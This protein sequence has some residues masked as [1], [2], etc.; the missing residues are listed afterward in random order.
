MKQLYLDR[1]LVSAIIYLCLIFTVLHSSVLLADEYIS[2]DDLLE[3]SSSTIAQDAILVDDSEEDTSSFTNM[4]ETSNIFTVA[5]S[6]NIRKQCVLPDNFVNQ[7]VSSLK[8]SLINSGKFKVVT[9][10]KAYQQEL[11]DELKRVVELEIMDSNSASIDRISGIRYIAVLTFKSFAVKKRDFKESEKYKNGAIEFRAELVVQF[12]NTST[13]TIDFHIDVTAR[14]LA[15]LTEKYNY[16]DNGTSVDFTFNNKASGGSDRWSW[17]GT[18]EYN[19]TAPGAFAESNFKYTGKDSDYDGVDYEKKNIY[20]LLP[21]QKHVAR[22]YSETK[23][24][25]NVRQK[26]KAESKVATSGEYREDAMH[27]EFYNLS[28]QNFAS[29]ALSKLAD[30][31]ADKSVSKLSANIFPKKVIKILAN[32]MLAI[33][34]GSENGISLGQTY[35]ITSIV[36]ERDPDT[37]KMLSFSVFVGS[38]EISA[39][40]NNTAIAELKQGDIFKIKVGMILT[41]NAKTQLNEFNTNS[42][43]KPD[44]NLPFKRKGNNSKSKSNW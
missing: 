43:S 18:D 22:N 2:T 1:F 25:D 13:R 19:S 44:S 26:F 3:N 11:Q 29:D 30:K 8:N 38:V 16:I 32:N 31:L 15:A 41:E 9:L 6:D 12:I 39:V 17:S 28:Q 7:V 10:D 40:E 34:S 14:Q 42:E 27:K 36:K 4:N 33:N 37:G 35:T 21:N 5:I 24:M 20:K 23:N